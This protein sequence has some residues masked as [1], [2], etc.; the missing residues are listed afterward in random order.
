MVNIMADRLHHLSIN[1][2][3]SVS[4]STLLCPC[5]DYLSCC[6]RRRV[7]RKGSL[8]EPLS[9]YPRP[10]RTHELG[11]R[12]MKT[13][14]LGLEP[15]AYQCLHELANPS[16]SKSAL[17]RAILDITKIKLFK[18]FLNTVILLNSSHR[19]QKNKGK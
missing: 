6:G 11:G 9:G 4:R 3:F 17:C 12:A 7:R 18:Q 15:A 1:R 5:T 13:E 8:H 16:M 10:G 14:L 2:C 19:K